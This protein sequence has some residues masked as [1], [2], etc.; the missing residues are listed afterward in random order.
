MRDLRG[1]EMRYVAFKL[2]LKEEGHPSLHPSPSRGNIKEPRN[3]FLSKGLR[4][5]TVPTPP[6]DRF[7]GMP[8]YGKFAVN[9][10]NVNLKSGCAEHRVSCTLHRAVI[11]VTSIVTNRKKI[12]R[13]F[14]SLF[15]IQSIAWYTFPPNILRRNIWNV[16]QWQV[17]IWYTQ[18]MHPIMDLLWLV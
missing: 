16:E 9:S 7:L 8:F 2:K 4:S 6:S 18:S 3:S 13:L 1:N 12:R 5:T 14:I 10:R 15:S 11:F 17:P